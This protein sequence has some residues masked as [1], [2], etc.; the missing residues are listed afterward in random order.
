MDKRCALPV[1][2]E[3]KVKNRYNGEQVYKI[4]GEVAR[5]VSCIV[6]DAI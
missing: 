3:L 6:Y 2:Y 1:G 4:K 5:G